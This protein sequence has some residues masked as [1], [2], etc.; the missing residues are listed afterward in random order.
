MFNYHMSYAELS[1]ALNTIALEKR[2]LTEH[3]VKC[4]DTSLEKSF[5]KAMLTQYPLGHS[6]RNLLQETARRNRELHAPK[7]SMQ[8]TN[9]HREC[10]ISI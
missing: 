1:T 4:I 10:S 9:T 3:E 2:L 8:F 7:G 5:L 6:A